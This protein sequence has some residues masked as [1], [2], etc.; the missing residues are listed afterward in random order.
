M[1]R[2]SAAELDLPLE[3]VKIDMSAISIPKRGRFDDRSSA[4]CEL[5]G[6]LTKFRDR[7]A[8]VLGL[9]RGGVPV[10]HEVAVALGLPLD[11]LVVRKLGAPGNRELAIGAIGEGGIVLVD[12]DECRRLGVGSDELQSIVRHA[13]GDLELLARQLRGDRS[14]AA[15]AG[16][17]VILVDDGVATGASAAAAIEV[18]RQRGAGQVVLAVPVASP[19]AVEALGKKADDLVALEVPRR[20]LAVGAYYRDFS[21]VSSDRAAELLSKGEDS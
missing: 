2:G 5:A 20:L 16:K 19:Q 4:G 1:C 11:V 9:P 10:A 6:E 3:L 17:T 13:Q 15:V 21:P 7:D 14:P 8:V 12:Q 18:L